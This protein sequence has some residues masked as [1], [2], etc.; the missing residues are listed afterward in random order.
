MHSM[1]LKSLKK[2]DGENGQKSRTEMARI[3]V[4]L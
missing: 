1:L 4:W 3:I 2:R